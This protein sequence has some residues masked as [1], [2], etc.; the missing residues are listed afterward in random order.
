MDAGL[1]D[2]H[3]TEVNPVQSKNALPLI[4][5]TEAGILIVLNPEQPLKAS[6][7]IILTVFGITELLVPR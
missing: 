1:S 6:S 3:Q 4:S 7:P 2:S 5:V